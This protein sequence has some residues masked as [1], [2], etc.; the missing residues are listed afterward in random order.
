MHGC[1]DTSELFALASFVGTSRTQKV[2]FSTGQ[3]FMD[4][5]PQQDAT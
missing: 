4:G 5:L 3:K 2:R 1:G